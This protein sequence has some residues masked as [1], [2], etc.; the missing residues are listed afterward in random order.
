MNVLVYSGPGTT[1]DSV[2]H[3]LETLRR[4]L[5]P[6][7]AVVAVGPQVIKNEPWPLKTA[8]LVVPGGAD[9][10][11]CKELNG[12]GNEIIKNYVRKGGKYIG[13]CSGGYYGSS[14]CE[15]EVGDLEMEVS[16]SRELQFYPGV[17]RGAAFKGFVY[18]SE[19]GSKAVELNVS[20]ELNSQGTVFNYYNGGAVFIDPLKYSN[21]EVLAS[22]KSAIDIPS[23]SVKAAV[24]YCK[25]GS[26]AALLTGSHPEFTPDLMHT[27]V[28][29]PSYQ[30]VVQ[31][32]REHDT[33]RVQFLKSCLKK[34]DLKVNDEAT[35]RPRLTPLYLTSLKPG[36]LPKLLQDLK[37]NIGFDD[38]ML[39][40]GTNDTFRLHDAQQSIDS[41]IHL[42]K[43]DEFEDPDTAIK[44]VYVFP[45]G[46]LPDR[47]LTPYFNIYQYYTILSH[48]S[49]GQLGD[50]GSTIAYGEVVTST[51][52]MIDK[53]S[54]I[55]RHLPNGYTN[56]GTTQVSG[57]GRGGNV[58]VNPPGVLAFSTNLKIP[59]IPS[60]P[61]PPIVFNQYLASISVV[62]SVLS[63]GRTLANPMDYSQVPIKIK[64]P[65]D[66]YLM[67]PEM[68]GKEDS[69]IDQE[70]MYLK[71]SGSLVNTNV[72]DRCYFIVIGTGINV[73]NVAPTTS[74]NLLIDLIN[75]DNLNRGLPLLERISEV[76]LLAN[77]MNIFQRL[78][79]IFE[80]EGFND[81]LRQLYYK[82]WFHTGQFV[83]VAANSEGGHGVVGRKIKARIT[84]I[85]K[86][87][88]LL[89]ADE[90]DFANRPTGDKFELQPDG[91]SFDM[92]NGLISKKLQMWIT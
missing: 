79:T 14:R 31:T 76:N 53:N 6:Y 87:W 2:K 13:F 4:F 23:D 20:H 78:Y 35:A 39:L 68:Y 17:A 41:S 32:L 67:K 40:K 77:F 8:L 51:S 86:D 66:V 26:G 85:S 30:S 88:G 19:A 33:E 91:N 65:N 42:N 21:V 7:Y 90:V 52:T 62:E 44:E 75:R 64:W 45:E 34:L 27:S 59:I 82:H 5:S 49:G 47:K 37:E 84:G 28:D 38:S 50:L 60:R 69:S 57:R 92:F 22:Y 80:M 16:G 15:F 3:C 43:Q 11:V 24:V 63:Y 9:L 83:T 10:P 74:I 48:L 46:Q 72:L 29:D 61:S 54:N 18:N 25:V 70:P 71:I 56:V 1:A 58:W 12:L 36:V 55:L 73:S 81:E 89:M